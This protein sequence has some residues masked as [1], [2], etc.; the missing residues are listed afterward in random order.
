[1]KRPDGIRAAT[2]K[3]DMSDGWWECS[4]TFAG[5]NTNKRDLTL[6]MQT[7]QGR[8]L[9]RKLVAQSDIVIE[10]YSRRVMD[11]WGMSYDELRKIRPDLI[12]VRAPGFGIEG[13]WADRVAYATTIEQAS[14]CAWVTGYADDRPDCA[15]GSL[16]PV[17]G[18]HAVFATLLALEHRRRTGTGLLVEVPQFASGFNITAEQIIEYSAHGVLLGRG[19]NRSWRVAPQGAYRVCDV[20]RS[21]A[22]VPS[23]EWVAIS[24]ETDEQWLAL[25]HT[26]NDAALTANQEIRTVDGRRRHHD[27]IDVAIGE[28]TRTQPAVQVIDALLSAGIPAALWVQSHELA[29][30]SEV[31]RRGLYEMVDNPG[32]GTVPIVG[33]PAQ[34]EAGPHQMHRRRAPLLGEHN[35]EILQGLLGLAPEAVDALE[36]DGIIGTKAGTATAW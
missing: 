7:E 36:T 13:P 18:T 29:D 11:H 28:W 14:G 27:A 1:T 21:V 5:T 8:E 33:Y 26:M 9:A 20:E 30:L 19:G 34:F 10:N 24:V 35:R 4:P 16:D 17:A 23:D 3:A 25:C 22:M 15:G 32:L 2:L 6:D 31:K 12:M